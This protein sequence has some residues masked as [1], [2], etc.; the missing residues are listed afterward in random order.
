[1][2]M[3]YIDGKPYPADPD[4][5]LLQVCLE[6]GFDLP[7]FCWHP[8]LGSVGSCR[9]CAV[10]QFRD[11]NDTKG[12]IVMACMTPA[13]EGTRISIDDSDA[14]ALRAS[15]IEW[16]MTNHPHD[17]PVCEEGGECHLQD[18]TVMAGHTYRR[19]R[20]P[21]R[22]FRNQDLGPFIGHEMNRCITCYRC[23]R[24]Y[25]DYAGGRDLHQLAIANHVYFGRHQDGTL[26]NEFSGNL[27]EV[28]PTGV[29]T[30]KTF[31]AHYTRKWDLQTAPSVCVH[32]AVGCN[33]QPGERYGQLLR[34]M[35]RYHDDL[36]G[37][38]LCD[39][40]RFGYGFVNSEHRVRQV[41][42]RGPKGLE[43]AS[44][45]E[46]LPGIGALV[47][48]GR[49]IG[50]GSPRASLEA[51]FLLRELVGPGRFFAGVSVGEHRLHARMLEIL[52]DGPTPA[53]TPAQAQRADCVLVIGEDITNT[54]P[55]LTLSIRHAL[56]NKAR[57]Q[58]A[59]VQVPPW[60]DIAVEQASGGARHPLFVL[61]PAETPLDADARALLHGAPDTLARLGYALAYG[62]HRK[63]RPV[64]DLS[65]AEAA[66]VEEASEAL[67]QAKRP[68]IVS[69]SGCGSLAVLDAVADLAWALHLEDKTPLL[70][71]AA[72]EANSLGLALME[73]PPADAAFAALDEQKADTLIILENDL[74]RRAPTAAVEA[75]LAKAKRVIV[76]DQLQ[77]PTAERAESL[78]PAAT[79]AESDGSLVNAEGRAQRYFKV[80]SPA[81]EGEVQ[82][83]WRWLD[84]VRRAADPQAE[85]YPDVE[86][87]TARMAA[88]MPAWRRVPAASPDP[89]DLRRGARVPRATPR[90]S[91]R[92]AEHAHEHVKEMPPPKDA[93][94]PL[95]F[96]ME[97]GTAPAPD[98]PAPWYWA[99][100]WNSNEAL[101]RFQQEIPGPLREG[102]PGVRIVEHAEQPMPRFVADPP[103]PFAPRPDQWLVTP[104][105]HIFGGEELSAQAPAVAA[106]APEPYVALSAADARTLGVNRGDPLVIRLEGGELRLN[107]RI[108]DT[109]QPGTAG[110]P[111]GLPGLGG[112]LLPAWAEV[113]PGNSEGEA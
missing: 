2:K 94:S 51:N 9:Q 40:G 54:N 53:A 65:E 15:V 38:F 69:G 12:R 19:T 104:L 58:A 90:Y 66:F 36:N 72:A 29:F 73:A 28:C 107:L 101:N 63:A 49:A 100:G 102:N 21:K 44:A 62:V 48:E 61:A 56:R 88:A 112:V 50:I 97:T 17:C 77:T 70:W 32:C 47:R 74:Y 24:Y 83:S 71:L 87:V 25:R 1:M 13:S 82:A 85:P 45:D 84:A 43:A 23:V 18:M 30:D 20:F 16:L 92:T 99:P 27:V 59:K 52:R 22:T 46:V 75:A 110:L 41:M 96:S 11:E 79:F 6:L 86:A 4:R 108:L 31:S 105:H 109:L 113:R 98:I 68:L 81:A 103:A 60:Q 3:L 80:L 57:E 55:R 10:K 33:T 78:L 42:Q 5:N 93:D 34:I 64:N 89:S 39:R 91:G 95:V 37:Y 8:V 111:A 14:R 35:N 7:Y 106:R 26:E 76:L 67:R